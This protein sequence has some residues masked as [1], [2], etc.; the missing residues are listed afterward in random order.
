MNIQNQSFEIICIF[1]SDW[2]SMFNLVE[3]ILCGMK[4]ITMLVNYATTL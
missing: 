1:S 4:K 2:F 3:K